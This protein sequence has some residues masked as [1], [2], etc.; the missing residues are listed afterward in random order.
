MADST[1]KLFGFE[2]TRTKDKKSIK[3]IV[4][5]RDDDGA[6]YVTSS[7]SAAHYGHYVN[8]EGDDSKDNVQLILKYRGSAMHPEADAAREDI[9]N[10]SITS[11]DMKPALTGTLSKFKVSAGFISLEVI[12]SFTISSLAASASGC[13][14]EPRYFNIN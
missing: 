8:M 3:S 12:D 14:A 10:E 13:M 1:L 5:P 7:T 9:V 4:P 2:I 11:S 6:G